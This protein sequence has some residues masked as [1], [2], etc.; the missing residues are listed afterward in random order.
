M[1]LRFWNSYLTIIVNA[2]MVW[3][4]FN[5]VLKQIIIAISVS[6]IV[7]YHT[8]SFLH[9][10]DTLREIRNFL[11]LCS[12]IALDS[13]EN[14]EENFILIFLGFDIAFKSLVVFVCFW[15][16]IIRDII[17]IFH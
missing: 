8:N 7:S 5:T 11:S 12:C 17:N 13:S 3:Y 4:V 15:T 16:N 10:E 9:F 1:A 14:F 6:I 2:I